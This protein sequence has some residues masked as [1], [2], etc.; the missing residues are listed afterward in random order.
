LAATAGLFDPNYRSLL[1]D[2]IDPATIGF[3]PFPNPPRLQL[4]VDLRWVTDNERISNGAVPLLI[5]L[6]NAARLRR[7]FADG[8]RFRGWADLVSRYAGG[9]PLLTVQRSPGAAGSVVVTSSTGAVTLPEFKEAVLFGNE[10]FVPFE[11]LPAGERAGHSV[12]HLS[13]P[14]YELGNA[15]LTP[16]GDE[17]IFHGTGWALGKQHVITNHHV[18]NARRQGAPAA[19]DED[20]IR[21]GSHTRIRFDF[22]DKDAQGEQVLSAAVVAWNATLD[23]AVLKTD[24]VH[25]RTPLRRLPGRFDKTTDHIPVN[26]IQHP[27]GG[28]KMLALRNNL[29]TK[30]T[31]TDV[32]YLT[33]TKFG[34]SG[35]P[36][37]DDR[38]NVVALHRGSV[39]A[40]GVQYFGASSVWVNIGTQVASIEDDL[41][42][43]FPAVW[44]DLL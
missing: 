24:R 33:D 8:V 42:E 5:W 27:D 2:G 16:L 21:Q 11:F 36:V 18:I 6:K 9:E 3:I 44:A 29:V 43:K 26:I 4:L 23:Y 41:K 19:S 7:T 15:T 14:V 10:Q 17:T 37:F 22:D 38:W 40:E 30:S 34:S 31:E 25:G 32:C 13:V 35:S 1:L 39:I 28:P 20:F 12:A